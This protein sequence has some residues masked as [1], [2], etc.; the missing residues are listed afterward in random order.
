MGL[1]PRDLSVPGFANACCWWLHLLRLLTCEL[2]FWWV[3]VR[4]AVL[5]YSGCFDGSG[6]ADPQFGDFLGTC[7]SA[8]IES[9]LA[10][11][12]FMLKEVR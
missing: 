10:L 4:W 1:S 12:S 7:D 5:R 8:N 6:G 11:G 2:G 3:R 9:F